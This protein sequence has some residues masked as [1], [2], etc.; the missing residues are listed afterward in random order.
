[1]TTLKGTAMPHASIQV[2]SMKN[3]KKREA[4]G[5]NSRKI[6]QQP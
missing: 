6:A 5:I 4:K 2:F 1:M 3:G